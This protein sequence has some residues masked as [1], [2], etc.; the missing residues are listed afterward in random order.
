MHNGQKSRKK[1]YVDS[2]TYIKDNNKN[3]LDKYPTIFNT[4]IRGENINIEYNHQI[5]K[6]NLLTI[7]IVKPLHKT[8]KKKVFMPNNKKK[9]I[10]TNK[11][12]PK[13]YYGSKSSR[14][15]K[16]KNAIQN[17]GNNIKSKQYY[18][19]TNHNKKKQFSFDHKYS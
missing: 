1:L 19:N 14:T 17:C 4:K 12:N 18:R 5:D 9:I 13:K 2:N 10:Q 7:S 16:I 8:I 11:Q 6:N 15:N 3:I